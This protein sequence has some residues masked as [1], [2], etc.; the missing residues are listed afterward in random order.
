M[1]PP[2]WAY[3][4]VTLGS[5][6]V[7]WTMLIEAPMALYLA[8]LTSLPGMPNEDPSI[9]ARNA[10]EADAL[11]LVDTLHARAGRRPLRWLLLSWFTRLGVIAI[12]IGAVL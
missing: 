11:R 7:L 1:P 4:V 8:G 9:G 10:A 3:A 6:Y 5:L 2:T 12:L